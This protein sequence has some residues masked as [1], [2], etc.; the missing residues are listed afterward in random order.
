LLYI[1][2]DLTIGYR[3]DRRVGRGERRPST[4]ASTPWS[5]TGTGQ[6]RARCRILSTDTR[7]Q[8][9]QRI[10]LVRLLWSW[11]MKWKV[12]RIAG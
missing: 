9:W 7:M 3:T 10:R 12:G 5:G 6:I 4:T 8:S 11:L 2:R 1:L